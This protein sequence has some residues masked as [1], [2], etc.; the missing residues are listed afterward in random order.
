MLFQSIEFLVLLL[1]VIGGLL[2]LSRARQQ[3]L[4]L[5]GASYIFY[6]WWDVRFLILI[7]L[8]SILDHF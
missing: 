2:T 7:L 4:M 5:L 3:H 8:S 6:G 1:A